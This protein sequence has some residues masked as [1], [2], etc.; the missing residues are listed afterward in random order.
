MDKVDEELWPPP[1]QPAAG[2][3]PA[4][5]QEARD[6]R[7]SEGIQRHRVR[8][9]QPPRRDRGL[10]QDEIVRAAIAVADAE[11]ADA[12]SMRRI[13]RELNAGAMSLYWHVKS[14]NDLVRAMLDGVEAD[15]EVPESTGDWRADLRAY[16]SSMRELLLRHVWVMDFIGTPP[17][18]PNQAMNLERLLR[19][20]DGLGLDIA[21]AIWTG[22]T[23]ATYVMGSVTFEV[24]QG[25]FERY[26]AEEHADWSDE[27]R[28]AEREYYRSWFVTSGRYPHIVRL[29]HANIDPDAPETSSE[30]FEFGLDCLL[31]GIAAKLTP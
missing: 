12:V 22:M 8:G 10:S 15:I 28:A 16:A 25:H 27:D 1:F 17:L 3:R 9:A 11:G 26:R 29:M 14:K 30:R 5:R 18:G 13:A 2:R 23:V 6:Q 19:I 7:I 24:R 20:L 21:T 31:D 4:S